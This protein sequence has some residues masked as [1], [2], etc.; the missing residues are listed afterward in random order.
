MTGTPRVSTLPNGLT[1]VALRHGAVP[2]AS[3][4]LG[5][6]SGAAA[7]GPRRSGLAELT[8]QLLR[9]G[10]R[11]RGARSI[12]EA[13][14][15]LGVDLG[16]GVD[17]E[18]TRLG[19]TVPAA[20]FGLAIDLL[21]ELATRPSFP[22]RELA[23]QR[24]RTLASIRAGLDE[25]T[26]VA[27]RALHRE[28]FRGHPYAEPID[29]WSR[30]LARLSRPEVLGFHRR[31]YRAPG[32]CLVAAGVLPRDVERLLERKGGA[33]AQGSELRVVPPVPPLQGRRVLV[34]DKPDATQA[35]LRIGGHGCSARDPQLVACMAGST[36]LGGGFSSRLVDEVRVN[37][38]L[39]YG[40]SSS[41]HPSRAGGL[42]VIRSATRVDEAR[43]LVEVSLGELERLRE[44]GPGEA[45]LAQA[46]SYLRGSFEL[47]NETGEQVAATL[48]GAF[49]Q[50]LGTDWLA[51]F[52]RLLGETTPGAVKVA[53]ERH[54]PRALRVV[55]VGPAGRL[56]RSLRKLGPVEV[57]TLASLA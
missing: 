38:G 44:Q 13:L 19:L 16:L 29:G 33:L 39:A 23:A 40:I 36:V 27:E 41:F 14:E 1:V 2:L 54:L 48:A 57:V 7:A 17:D 20:R 47:G 25:P 21:M 43:S 28:V 35:T 5:F 56:E 6:A 24:S 8:A 22:A 42:F 15:R 52:P 49:L 11:R 51:R 4:R 10:T 55:A 32:G 26:G 31:A 18:A 50:G 34:I 53:L 12:D 46:V 3:L 37:R 30:E 9:R 45:E